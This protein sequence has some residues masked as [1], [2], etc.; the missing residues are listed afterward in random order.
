MSV[1]LISVIVPSYNQGHWIDSC[2]RSLFAQQDSNLE[3][4]VV[5]GGSTDTTL[6]VLDL[7]RPQL[8][9]CI[10]ERDDGQADAIA[11][12]FSMARG[13]IL[14]WLNSDDMHLPWTISAWRKAFASDESLEMVHG[15]RVI[16]DAEGRVTG[17][18]RLPGHSGYWLNRFPWTHQETAAW[19]R[20]LYERAGGVD[21][22]MHFA[23][24]YDLFARFFEAAHCAHLPQ[25]LGVFR[26][27]ELSKSAKIQATV[28]ADEM[29]LVRRRRGIPS[30]S[31]LHPARMTM[32]AAVRGF[33]WLHGLRSHDPP[34]RLT[35]TGHN[36]SDLWCEKLW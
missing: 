10:V 14:A 24:D 16:V 33:S 13:E 4:I 15:D 18:R 3:V 12:G 31:R 8:A 6:E 32:S 25:Y 30:Y 22:S 11:K 35:C 34:H 29:A 21:R 28:G 1:P 36:I 5:D 17:Y 20:G 19:R 7:W 23:M 9:A 26:W 27:H 2:L